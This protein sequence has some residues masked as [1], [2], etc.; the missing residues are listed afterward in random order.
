[1]PSR[2]TMFIRSMKLCIFSKIGA[3]RRTAITA[4]TMTTA[5]TTSIMAPICASIWKASTVPITQMMGT[6]SMACVA[7]ITVCWMTFTSLR[8][9]VIMEPVP[10]CSKSL[11]ENVSEAS[12]T[13]SRMSRP[14]LAA[15]RAHR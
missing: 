10:K 15:R 6:G 13:A 2:N 9:R 11:P 1:M 3:A 8:V 4:N 14:T 12:Y 5:T 7:S